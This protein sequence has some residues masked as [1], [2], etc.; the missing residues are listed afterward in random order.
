MSRCKMNIFAT[1]LLFANAWIYYSRVTKRIVL[2][3]SAG[4]TS[5]RKGGKMKRTK[6]FELFLLEKFI[7][8]ID[9]V[10]GLLVPHPQKR[11]INRSQVVD[12]AL[13]GHSTR[14]RGM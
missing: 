1:N 9:S 8:S 10:Q 11:E 12:R 3:I 4:F 2:Q 14:A 13:L 6:T 5:R 7:K